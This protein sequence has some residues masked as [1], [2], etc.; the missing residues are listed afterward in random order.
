MT[1]HPC[2]W[3]SRLSAFGCNICTVSSTACSRSPRFFP[4]PV[5]LVEFLD[6]SRGNYATESRLQESPTAAKRPRVS[7]AQ[8]ER[9]SLSQPAC[10]A[11]VVSL[12]QRAPSTSQTHASEHSPEYRPKHFGYLISR[13]ERGPLVAHPGIANGSGGWPLREKGGGVQLTS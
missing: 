12:H 9:G 3:G 10:C 1:S 8:Y 11:D 7:D 13:R 6:G 4:F 2:P 5:S